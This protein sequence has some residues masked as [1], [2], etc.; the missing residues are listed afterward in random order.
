FFKISLPFGRSCKPRSQ[1]HHVVARRKPQV[2]IDDVRCQSLDDKY[3][4]HCGSMMM[5]V[6]GG[7]NHPAGPRMTR[8]NNSLLNG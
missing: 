7:G 5:L 8:L 4:F 1:V 3:E 6:V 2:E